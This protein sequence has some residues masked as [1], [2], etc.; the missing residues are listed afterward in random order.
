MRGGIREWSRRGLTGGSVETKKMAENG[1]CK[2]HHPPRLD[3]AT[4]SFAELGILGIFD[5]V[6]RECAIED[7]VL[8]CGVC[9]EEAERAYDAHGDGYEAAKD[10]LLCAGLERLLSAG[11]ER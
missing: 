8:Y 7:L 4:K 3:R 9:V 6:A 10:C 11:G 2:G 1:R 5:Q